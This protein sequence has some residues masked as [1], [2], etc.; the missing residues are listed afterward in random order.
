MS[1]TKGKHRHTPI[2]PSDQHVNVC[3]CGEELFYDAYVSRW[4]TEA[5]VDEYAAE[6]RAEAQYEDERAEWE[7]LN[8]ESRCPP[9]E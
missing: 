7:A 4:L 9:R 5:E 1:E 6:I 2:D 3:A 8:P